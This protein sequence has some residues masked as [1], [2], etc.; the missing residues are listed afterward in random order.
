MGTHDCDEGGTGPSRRLGVCGQQRVMLEGKGTAT[1]SYY[2]PHSKKAVL[3][4]PGRARPL[5]A[6]SGEPL[7]R[8]SIEGTED[9]S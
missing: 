8:R 7:L 3:V 6:E 4:K 2:S 9:P 5:W 1:R